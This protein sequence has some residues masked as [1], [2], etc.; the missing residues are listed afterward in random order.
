MN[1]I[2]KRIN[3]DIELLDKNNLSS[4]LFHEYDNQIVISRIG[5]VEERE[6]YIK[7]L[8]KDKQKENYMGYYI[9]LIYNIFTIKKKSREKILETII[10][11][12]KKWQ[13]E[14]NKPITQY[15]KFTSAQNHI[16][17]GFSE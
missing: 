4:Y 12:E 5:N 7:K 8:I 11:I 17:A 6:K 10:D 14:A 2:E 15:K 1:K 13:E 9:P 16:Y 3:K